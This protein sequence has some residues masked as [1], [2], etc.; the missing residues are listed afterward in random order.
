MICIIEKIKIM[1]GRDGGIDGGG[2][3]DK[4]KMRM[5]VQN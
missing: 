5:G 3:D 1:R 4:S 2:D